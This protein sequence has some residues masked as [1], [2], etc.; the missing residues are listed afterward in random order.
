MAYN[1]DSSVYKLTFTD[2][3]FITLLNVGDDMPEYSPGTYEMTIPNLYM[4]NFDSDGKS[5]IKYDSKG[6]KYEFSDRGVLINDTIDFRQTNGRICLGYDPIE[7]TIA[8]RY[9]TPTSTGLPV[10]SKSLWSAEG[11]CYRGDVQGTVFDSFGE[12]LNYAESVYNNPPPTYNG[13]YRLEYVVGRSENIPLY[14]TIL[15]CGD[16]LPRTISGMQYWNTV[17]GHEE[18][19]DLSGALEDYDP[20]STKIPDKDPLNPGGNSGPSDVTGDFDG[21]SDDIDIPPLPTLGAT[22]T[23]FITLFNP[24][25][26]QLQSLS[27][28]L[29]SSAFDLN[30]FK[31]LFANPMDCILGLSIVPVA[32]PNGSSKEIKVG[33]IPTGLYMTVAGQQY[34]EVDCGSLNV[35]EYWSAYLDYE[36]FTRAELYLPYIGTHAISVDDIMG[37]TVTIKYHVDILSGS[38]TAYVQCGSSVLYEFIGQCS[39][40]IPINATDWTNTI[41]GAVTIAG[42]IGTMFAT[43]GA[44][45]PTSAAIATGTAVT[46]TMVTSS[47]PSIEK[48]GSMSGTGGMMGIQT[49]YLIL[50]RPRQA[51]PNSQNYFTG[52]PSFITEPLSM[53]SGYT[54][55]ESI[56]L[57]NVPGTE[58]EVIEI[59][60][61]LKEG[62]I[63]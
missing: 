23:G 63:F 49:P 9:Y 20:T 43:Y 7:N 13:W 38:C 58:E 53:V 39:S 37:K 32:I 19:L 40:N 26:A 16:T 14:G 3:T 34:I 46:S 8:V 4:G 22:D 61:L 29:W 55:I 27:A 30:N 45:I 56:R 57:A 6:N 5:Y 41:M 18:S 33:G 47:K 15:Y 52:Y 25:L 54:E 59:V 62:V 36:P 51:L 10:M 35:N 12:A 48:S 31:K 21:T 17:S 28:Y 1:T 60:N 24:S 50:T 2:G 44:S 11:I 42:A